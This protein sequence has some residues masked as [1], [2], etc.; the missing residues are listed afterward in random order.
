VQGGARGITAYLRNGTNQLGYRGNDG[1]AGLKWDVNE[2]LPCATARG[3]EVY[4]DIVGY[5]CK[6][7]SIDVLEA[8]TGEV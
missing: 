7:Y 1:Y 3:Q 2:L 5:G 6:I 4:V 8:W